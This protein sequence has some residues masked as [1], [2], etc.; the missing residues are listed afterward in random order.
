LRG[1]SASAGGSHHI[2]ISE[3]SSMIASSI[4]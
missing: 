1:M 4:A 3:D 2:K